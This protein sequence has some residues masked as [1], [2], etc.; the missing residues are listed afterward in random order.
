MKI[1][2]RPPGG[3]RPVRIGSGQPALSLSKRPRRCLRKGMFY[4]RKRLPV[5]T[6]TATDNRPLRRIEAGQVQSEKTRLTGRRT[7]HFPPM[8]RLRA[9]LFNVFVAISLLLCVITTLI[10]CDPVRGTFAS[11][12]VILDFGS[13]SLFIENRWGKLWEI[14]LG[15][16][17]LLTS[18]LPL[19]WAALRYASWKRFKARS[20]LGL[21]PIC[22][23]DLR[24]TP[25]QC[26]ECG[27]IPAKP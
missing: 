5:V 8:K 12:Y 13:G 7:I 25:D 19:T 27:T 10:L 26:P 1:V 22:G 4:S 14:N 9:R 24:A 20:R 6:D 2:E 16:L 21:C 15:P 11:K 18:I 3:K 17:F 23:Y